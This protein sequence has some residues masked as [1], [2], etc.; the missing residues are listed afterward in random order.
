MP[1]NAIEAG[2]RKRGFLSGV[3]KRGEQKNKCEVHVTSE[4]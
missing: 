4:V 2:A 3:N 1:A